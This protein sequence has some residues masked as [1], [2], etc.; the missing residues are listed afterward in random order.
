M[1]AFSAKTYFDFLPIELHD[2]ILRFARTLENSEC[3]KCCLAKKEGNVNL[4]KTNYT[5]KFL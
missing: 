1:L 4:V 2:I 5:K 3:E